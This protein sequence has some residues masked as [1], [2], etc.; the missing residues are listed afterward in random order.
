MATLLY[1]I[2]RKKDGLFL[3]RRG[4]GRKWDEEGHTYWTPTAC[5]SA[6]KTRAFVSYGHNS[7]ARQQ[8]WLEFRETIEIVEYE[9]SPT[10]EVLPFDN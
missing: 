10:G 4:M 1:K 3:T 6:A 9:L 2:R 7:F 8:D 5:K